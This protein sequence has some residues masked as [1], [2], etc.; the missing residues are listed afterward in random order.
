[1]TTPGD[2]VVNAL[3][4]DDWVDGLAGDDRLYGSADDDT[5]IGGLGNDQLDGGTGVDVMTGGDDND[6]YYVDDADDVV[7]E[8]PGGGVDAIWTTLSTYTLDAEVEWLRFAGTGDFTGTGNELA[9]RLWGGGGSDILAGGLGNDRL[10]GGLG[11]DTM[12]GGG[13]DDIYFVD[14]PSDRAIEATG[15]GTDA[16]FASVNFT[17][18]VGQ[19]I[20]S[21][22]GLGT[23]GLMLTGNE[24]DN[25]LLG[26]VGDDVLDGGAGND[27]VRAGDGSDTITTSGASGMIYAGEGDDTIRIDGASTSSGYVKG[28]AGTDTVRSADL[29]QFEFRSVEV[30]DTYYGFLNATVR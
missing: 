8:V 14:D 15:A 2:D 6:R 26:T 10:D 7:S 3:G 19:E 9:N 27:E 30:L 4:G 1:M 22:F 11:A 24:F 12:E 5:L 29:G 21:L 20:E 18:E 16:V 25:L 17:L 13:G 23:T 28:G